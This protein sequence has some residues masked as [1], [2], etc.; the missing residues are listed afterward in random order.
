MIVSA[1]KMWLYVMKTKMKKRDLQL[2]Y[3]IRYKNPFIVAFIMT[4]R[5]I[6]ANYIPIELNIVIKVSTA[7]KN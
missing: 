2:Y 3:M 6:F 7:S 4:T 1:N 5:I